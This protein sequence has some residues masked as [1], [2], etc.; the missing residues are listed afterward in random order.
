MQTNKLE[1]G[2]YYNFH[3]PGDVSRAGGLSPTFMEEQH[4]I[5]KQVV[6]CS[7]RAASKHL[8]GLSILT[9]LLL[10]ACLDAAGRL[11]LLP[12]LHATPVLPW[13]VCVCAGA[14]SRRP[15]VNAGRPLRFFIICFETRSFIEAGAHWFSKVIWPACSGHLWS[16]MSPVRG[17]QL[18]VTNP[19][20]CAWML[21]SK[22]Q[23]SRLCGHFADWLTSIPYMMASNLFYLK[24]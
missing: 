11:H 1:E 12:A 4:T 2:C 23:F 20:P 10:H 8:A 24:C 7:S 19:G 17:Q 15:E 16:S 18:C 6:A 3:A 14:R 9:Q 13:M 21:G 5:L 22:A